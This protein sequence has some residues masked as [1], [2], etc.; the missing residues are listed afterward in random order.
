MTN[1]DTTAG[2]WDRAALAVACFA[3]DPAA[4][5]GVWLRARAGPVRDRFLTGLMAALGGQPV[6]RL[7]P[8]MSDE[9]LFGGLDLAATLAQHTRVQ[10]RGMLTD[11]G[12]LILPM[13]ERAT[14]Q[15]AGRVAAALDGPVA[16]SL[17]ALDEGVDPDERLP[18]TLADRLAIHLDL[19][20]LALADAP[21]LAI[22]QADLA[23]ARVVLPHVTLP[24]T[25]IEQVVSTAHDLGVVG[26]RGP[27]LT[28]AVARAA[29]ALVGETMVDDP[30]LITAVELVLA[31]RATRWPGVADMPADHASQEQSPP[32]EMQPDETP[33]P[34]MDMPPD[35]GDATLTPSVDILLE[36]AKAV[37]P[38]DVLAHMQTGK[39][40]RHPSS[41][42]GVGAGATHAAHRRGRPMPPRPGRP[43]HAAR[44]DLIATLRAAAPWQTRRRRAARFDRPIYVR[45]ADIH[46]RRFEETTTR[47]IIFVVDA[48]GSAAMARLAEAK[49]AVE[50][51]LA[52]A[53]ARR[54]HAA[55]IAFRGKTA[56]LLLPPTRS[57]VRAKR[58]LAAVPGGGGTPL[59]AGLKSAFDLA[60][61]IRGGGMTPALAL[62]TDGRANVDLQGAADRAQAMADAMAMARAIHAQ[63]VPTIVV[64]TGQRLNRAL[65]DLARAMG[66]SYVPM[67]HADATALRTVVDVS[68]TQTT[69]TSAVG[70][71]PDPPH[72]HHPWH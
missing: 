33:S 38:P 2:R 60:V 7:H 72:T 62:L 34:P 5:G 57:L 9:A 49:G 36:A 41:A 28:L 63:A 40:M 45:S 53:Y 11:P 54:D 71:P 17:V 19:A 50:L 64:D 31:P 30:D 68:L 70:A 27:L 48:S 22:D 24:Q 26:A 69:A 3:L 6:R 16:V 8:T 56:D 35:A 15:F 14:P 4:L 25:A 43:E 58:R 18:N 65:G 20:D 51:L 39:N 47:A 13:A 67:P 46:V 42:Q 32:G 66:G 52:A 59:A 29:A 12:I 1:P 55:L 61:K 10:T 37:L 44:V 23:K 21:E